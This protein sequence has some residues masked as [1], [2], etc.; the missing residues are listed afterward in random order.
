MTSTQLDA[1]L[2][3]LE[4]SVEIS[5]TIP[6][7]V[8][9]IGKNIRPENKEI[10]VLKHDLFIDAWGHLVAA[11]DHGLCW[12]GHLVN[13]TGDNVAKEERVAAVHLPLT[14]YYFD[15]MCHFL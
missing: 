10:W 14:T 1:L 11:R 9:V 4:N 3:Q 8:S 15:L 13:D 7:A 2:T 5:E 6:K 12:I